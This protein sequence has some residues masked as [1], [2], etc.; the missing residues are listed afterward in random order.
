MHQP[1]LNKVIKEN[2]KKVSKW[3][4]LNLN[5]FNYRYF[6]YL[7]HSHIFEIGINVKREFSIYDTIKDIN[8]SFAMDEDDDENR[9]DYQYD[10]Q[11][12]IKIVF[13]LNDAQDVL[14]KLT[15]L[16][17][18]SNQFRYEQQP[19]TP[20]VTKAQW[21]TYLNLINSGI[22]RENIIILDCNVDCVNTKIIDHNDILNKFETIAKI[23][24]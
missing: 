23:K 5:R 12:Q 20:V 2:F 21:K 1:G 4:E 14:Q 15:N 6:L 13:K 10:M 17:A 24:S 16:E 3:I 22:H 7:Y 8:I 9:Y 18:I 11:C 19:L